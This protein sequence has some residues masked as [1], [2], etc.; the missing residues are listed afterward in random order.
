MPRVEQ[1]PAA[2]VRLVRARY[3]GKGLGPAD[4]PTMTVYAI[5]E[6]F[7]LHPNTVFNWSADDWQRPA[8]YLERRP[9][10][11]YE[12]G[13]PLLDLSEQLLALVGEAAASV[14][15][16]PT[17]QAL[18]QQLNCSATAISKR[19]RD[20]A[21][22]GRL[23]VEGNGPRRRVVFPDGRATGLTPHV[24]MPPSERRTAERAAVAE[25]RSPFDKAAEAVRRR[26][27]ILD[28]IKA[29]ALDARPCPSAPALA[30]AGQCSKAVV[31]HAFRCLIEAG[32]FTLERRPGLRR[33]VFPDGTATGW[34][35]QAQ[36]RQLVDIVAADAVRALQ[37]MG[38]TVFDVAVVTGKAR[39]LTWSVDGTRMSRAELLAHQANGMVRWSDSVSAQPKSRERREVSP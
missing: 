36:G 29:A 12:P 17:N 28:A 2:L 18:A 1:Y 5:A 31:A 34:P 9:K 15:P 26:E 33:V 8:W 14:A 35:G 30:K 37:R 23:T 39:G 19:L 16:C 25:R 22:A 21:I 10:R 3:E 20:L 38:C 24:G 6:A 11:K 13:R 32:A 7:A 4:A 27:R